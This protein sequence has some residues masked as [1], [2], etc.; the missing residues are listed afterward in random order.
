[1]TI[2]IQPIHKGN[3]FQQYPQLLTI[4]PEPYISI[5]QEAIIEDLEIDSQDIPLYDIGG[6]YL[7]EHN[8]YVIGI[9][10]FFITTHEPEEIYL[11]WH[12]VISNQRGNGYSKEALT[13]VLKET[14]AKYPNATTIIELV[15][16]NDYGL[17]LIK[18][19]EKLGFLAV[20]D[21]EKYDWADHYW[22]PYHLNISQFLNL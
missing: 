10:G 22:Q 13:L 12:G 3:P 4:W 8:N 20:G 1:M 5:V 11:R 19:F 2:N 7:I 21:M 17:P 9:T 18:H 16:M 15:P 14:L 6:I